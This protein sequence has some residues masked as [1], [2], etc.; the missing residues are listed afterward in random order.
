MKKKVFIS[1]DYDYDLELKNV[2]VGQA[3]NPDSP[4]TINDM[5][6]KQAIDSNWKYFARQK[7]RQCDIGI[8]ICGKHTNNASGVAAELSIMQEEGVPY[9]LLCGR[10]DGNVL[11]PSNAKNTDGIYKW[12][13]DNL[14]KL[15]AGNR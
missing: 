13:W 10:A 15:I 1:F 9:F 3:R 11:K 2:L 12:T 5:S 14:K 6:I 8:V 4:F 7:I